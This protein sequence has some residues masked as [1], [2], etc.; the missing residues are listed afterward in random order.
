[1]KLKSRM[2]SFTKEVEG[3]RGLLKK[4]TRHAVGIGKVWAQWEEAKNS[5]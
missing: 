5:Y 3:G 1:M 4:W 2:R